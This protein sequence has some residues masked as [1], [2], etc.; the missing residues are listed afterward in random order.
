M[1]SVN[2]ND[3]VQQQMRR[4]LAVKESKYLRSSRQRLDESTFEKIKTIGVG[5][6]G[7][8]VLVRKNDT[9]SLYA[10]KML[11][12]SDVIELNQAAHVKAERDILAEANTEWIVKLYCSFQ[13]T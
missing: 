10:M 12:K 4:I 8:V 9:D 1:A 3:H 2:F 5:A 6:F 13:V 7:K 11:R